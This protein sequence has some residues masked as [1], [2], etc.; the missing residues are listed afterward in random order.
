MVLAVVLGQRPSGGYRAEITSITR[1]I[2]PTVV[3]AFVTE[4]VPGSTCLTTDVI[5][6]PYHLVTVDAVEAEQIAF[7]DNGTQT[8]NCD[9]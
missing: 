6:V 9:S 8:A 3:R 1:N 4:T 2:N 5:T 7:P